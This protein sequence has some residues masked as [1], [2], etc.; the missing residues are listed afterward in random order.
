MWI[1]VGLP[2]KLTRTRMR[3]WRGCCSRRK[4][5][6]H[7]CRTKLGASGGGVE[8]EFFCFLFS[9]LQ[10]LICKVVFVAKFFIFLDKSS[11]VHLYL[12]V[13]TTFLVCIEQWMQPAV[14]Q[15]DSLNFA[16][17][18]LINYCCCC[19]NYYSYSGM[20]LRTIDQLLL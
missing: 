18:L 12:V 1:W 15:I 4:T 8:A 5:G 3:C 11:S 19:Y 20:L 9:E 7:L 14:F 10:V 13:Y 17:F 6:Q 16:F 2:C